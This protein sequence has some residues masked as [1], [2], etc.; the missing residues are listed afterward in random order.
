M[1]HL[2]L[3]SPEL[4]LPQKRTIARGLT[5]G[6]L[7]ALHLPEQ[8]RSSITLHFT[9]YYLDDIA[10][11]GEML[12]DLAEADHVV[13]ISAR[14]LTREKR[15][16]LNRELTPLLARLLGLELA[17]IGQI[18]LV[19]RNYEPHDMAVGGRFFDDDGH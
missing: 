5:E 10:I 2:R 13:E 6:V 19:F 9:P 14:G 18:S 12:S 7:R 8:S 11:G 16:A 3:Y 15:A 17:Q 4:T 1:T